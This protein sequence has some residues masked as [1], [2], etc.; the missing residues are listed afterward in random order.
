MPEVSIIVPVYNAEKSIAR[1]VDSIL[2]Q[3]Y[4]DFELILV[5]DGSKDGSPAILDA[6]AKQDARVKVIHKPNSGVSSTRNLALDQAKGKYI[7]FLDADDWIPDNSTKMMVRDAVDKDVDL[8]VGDFYRVVGKNV[9]RKGSIISNDVMTLQEFAEKM[10]NSPSDFYYG[11]LWNKLYKN[12][13]IQNYNVRMDEDL[14]WCED[15]IFNLE[16]LLHVKTVSALQIPVYYYV[17]TEGSLVA[18]SMSLTK[19]V[20]MKSNVFAYYNDFYKNVLDEKQYR[21]DRLA[22]AGFLIDAAGD[23]MI[24]PMLPGTKKLGEEQ[25]HAYFQ[26][27]V[28]N[29]VTA[30]YYLN[31]AYEKNLEVL[32]LKYD[33]DLKEVKVL[34]SLREIGEAN[35]FA[36]IADLSGMNDVGVA[37]I[38]MRLAVKGYVSVKYSAKKMTVSYGKNASDINQDIETALNDLHQVITK[39]LSEEDAEQGQKIL[40]LVSDN[41]RKYIK[42]NEN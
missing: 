1:C 40:K 39:N 33:L 36:E 18:K 21:K 31:K 5:D 22:I 38:V 24:I 4:E 37:S 3:E 13:I 23:D 35:S 17:K 9:S 29:T 34:A 2:H 20:D 30:A 15:F 7:Q 19:I 8:V 32:A 11:V 6:Y 10:M 41:L 12:E 42:A 26:G 28:Q 25:V 27:D 16:Y 14:S